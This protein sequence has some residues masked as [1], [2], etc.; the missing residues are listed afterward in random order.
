[1]LRR[2]G[3]GRG[4]ILVVD[5]SLALAENIAEVFGLE[6]LESV[7]AANAEEALALTLVRDLT[8]VITDLR[9][10]GIDGTELVN[11]LRPGRE[12]VRFA[13]ISAYSD[14]DTMNRAREVGA[15]FFPKPIDIGRLTRFVRGLGALA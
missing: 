4:H 11:R 7:V 6:G 12:H 15:S 3:N 13:L 14:E 1:M 2:N 8:A 5:D 9:L 10:P